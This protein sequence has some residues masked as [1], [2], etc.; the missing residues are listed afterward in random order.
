MRLFG[1][2]MFDSRVADK[3]LAVLLSAAAIVNS[4][5]LGFVSMLA[6]SYQHIHIPMIE[7]PKTPIEFLNIFPK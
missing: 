6:I 7:F 3:R 2:V 5:F 1:I 4:H